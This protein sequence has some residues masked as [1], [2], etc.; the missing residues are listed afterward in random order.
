MD[1]TTRERLDAILADEIALGFKIKDIPLYLEAQLKMSGLPPLKRVR[2]TRLNPAKRR[3]VNEAVQAQY[4]KDLKNPDILSHAQ[5]MQ[6]VQERGEWSPAEDTR[7]ADLQAEV[8]TELALLQFSA[9]E[10]DFSEQLSTLVERFG[11]ELEKMDPEQAALIKPVFDRWSVYVPDLQE[12]YT[13]DYAASQSL[14]SYSVDRDQSWLF[15]HCPT[16]EAIAVIEDVNTVRERLLSYTALT[17]KRR[18]LAEL[19]LKHAKIFSDSVESR[20]DVTE[21]MARL[22]FTC[23][24]VD[25]K[26]MPLGPLAPSFTDLWN[27]PDEVTQWL[28]IELYFFVRG[29]PESTREYLETTGFL[30]PSR[31]GMALTASS[32]EASAASP[33]AESSRLA[34]PPVATMAGSSSGTR[35]D[36]TL[37]ISS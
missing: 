7:M 19:Q 22:Y 8:N 34:T 35:V 1:D 24:R 11:V 12:A 10:P 4:H 23:E 9:D 14:D 2:F 3:K 16:L 25:E 28:T 30:T 15:D 26:D 13:K 32:E 5:I 18:T 17:E 36:S 37:T 6:L 27:F 29:L 31:D 33:E 21:E 20:R